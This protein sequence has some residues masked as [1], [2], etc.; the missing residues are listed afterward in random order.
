MAMNGEQNL[1]QKVAAYAALAKDNKNVDVGALLASAMEQERLDRV[2][3]KK[4]SRAYLISALLPPFG[5]LYAVRY[6]FS[7]KTDGKRIAS[8]CVVLTVLALAVGWLIGGAMFGNTP[9]GSLEQ[10]KT[11]N[12]EDVRSLIE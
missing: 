2:D 7:G 12:L 5:L 11:M 6:Y 3:A 8:M 4:R 1:E 9:T 10:M